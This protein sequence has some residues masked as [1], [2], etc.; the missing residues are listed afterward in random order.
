MELRAALAAERLR[1]LLA[2]PHGAGSGF[3]NE[4]LPA[5]APGCSSAYAS[6]SA[7]AQSR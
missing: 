5:G 7:S 6:C 3:R 1:E 2:M 4:L